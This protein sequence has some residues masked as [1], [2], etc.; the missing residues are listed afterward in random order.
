[1]GCRICGDLSNFSGPNY[2]ASGAR[3]YRR[4]FAAHQHHDVDSTDVKGQAHVK[5]A[6]EVAVAGGHNVS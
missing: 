3:L 5:R 6:I 1:M 2:A 4:F